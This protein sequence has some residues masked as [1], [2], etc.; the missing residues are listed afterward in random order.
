MAESSRRLL[1]ASEMRTSMVPHLAAG[2]MSK[3]ME[4]VWLVT[5]EIAWSRSNCSHCC[6]ESKWYGMP[7]VG[8]C[9]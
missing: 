3:C 4:P 9:W 7:A 8:S 2:R 1:V 5:P 6:Q